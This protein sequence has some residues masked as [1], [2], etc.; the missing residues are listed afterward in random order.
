V[1]ADLDFAVEGDAIDGF[2]GPGGWDAAARQLGI[3]PLGIEIDVRTCETREAAGLRTLHADITELDPMDFAPVVLFIASAPCQPWSAAGKREAERDREAV[4]RRAAAFA[5]GNL[6]ETENWVDERSRLAAEPMRWVA[7][8]RPR[9]VAFEQVPPVLGLFE[10]CA[11]L[12]RGLGYAVWAGLLSSE[13]Y[14]IPQTRERAFLLAIDGADRVDPPA[15]THQ[16]FIPAPK[17]RQD[18]TLFE[19]PEA[20]R[21]VHP[22]DV[23]LEPWISMADALGWGM[24]ERPY[25]VVASGRS[26]GEPDKE[27]VGGSEAREAIYR[28]MREGRWKMVGNAQSRATERT[29][30]E[31][32]PTIKGG[33][34]FGERRWEMVDTGCTR[35]G[36]QP[37]GGRRRGMDEPAP[38]LTSRADQLAYN[39]RD[40][41]GKGGDVRMVPADEPAPTIS[42]ESR[43]DSWVHDRPSTTVAGDPRIPAPGHKKDAEF[44][45]A[46]RR[47]EESIT[48]E[49]HEAAILQGF[50][51]DYPFKGSKTKQFEQVGNAV[52]PGFAAAVL[53]A[54]LAQGNTSGPSNETLRTDEGAPDLADAA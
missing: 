10:F 43:N 30:D 51:P 13:R 36:Q 14:G 44:P 25:P 29:G 38:P 39:R 42:G 54:L 53:K 15:P 11:D 49:I 47:M 12:L 45:D 35:S 1:T 48:V 17:A 40:Q 4:Y 52:P 37:D 22:E 28:E 41:S 46:P 3:D 6:P 32:A 26:T 24:T 2:G 8:L 9:F 27:K 5:K 31:P 16:R 21:I 20:Q 18:E 34:D 50:P 7:K 23:V 19:P 33:K